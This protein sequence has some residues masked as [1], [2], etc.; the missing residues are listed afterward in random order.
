M[1]VLQD[2]DRPSNNFAKLPHLLVRKVKRYSNEAVDVIVAEQEICASLACN[3]LDDDGESLQDLLGDVT[4]TV[5]RLL[6]NPKDGWSHD[7]LSI[8]NMPFA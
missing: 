5:R 2:S 3:V 7:T 1:V 4:A 8:S 6:H